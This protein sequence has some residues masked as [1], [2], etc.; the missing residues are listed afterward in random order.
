M[1]GKS[2][3][4]RERKTKRI[5][6]QEAYPERTAKRKSL[7]SLKEMIKEGI[8]EHQEGNVE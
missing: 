3:H 7:K 4:L 2:K 6:C 8:L 1:E 5:C